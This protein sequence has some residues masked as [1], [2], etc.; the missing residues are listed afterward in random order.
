MIVYQGAMFPQ[1]KDDIFVGALAG[2]MLVRLERNGKSFIEAERLFEAELGRVRD[3][4]THPDGSIYLLIDDD[5]GQI[6]RISN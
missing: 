2:M 4:R 6:I 5:P 3:V 1:W